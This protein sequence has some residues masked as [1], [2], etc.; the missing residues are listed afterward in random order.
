M[1]CLEV[2]ITDNEKPQT[3]KRRRPRLLPF[4]LGFLFTLAFVGG[5]ING[6]SFGIDDN[7]R[8]Q[9]ISSFY[10][11]L[12]QAASAE[13]AHSGT[14]SDFTPVL[15]ASL[16]NN[17]YIVYDALLDSVS[18]F[19]PQ[20]SFSLPSATTVSM[21]RIIEITKIVLN[22]PELYW[23]ES[24]TWITW[25]DNPDASRTYTIN[26][27]YNMDADERCHTQKSIDTVV[28]S[29]LEDA[30]C[31]TAQEAAEYVNDYLA[32]SV[33]YMSDKAHQTEHPYDMITGPLLYQQAIC[34]GY[35]KTFTY[36][37]AKLGYSSAYCLGYTEDGVF[38]AWNAIRQDGTVLYT[39]STFN[40][41]SS[42]EKKWLNLPRPS[43]G[44]HQETQKYWYEPLI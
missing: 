15:Q 30:D 19:S 13:S 41:S 32:S 18:Q 25:T 20:S 28:S 10:L 39:D 42:F 36:L 6:Y 4:F 3:K 27:D 26:I 43:F 40:A 35:A 12:P 31:Q 24:M 8:N 33:T 38:H 34:S 16:S 21:E 11:H 5:F 37:M 7:Q 22:D 14:C 17:E 2:G 23:L 1:Q 9:L 44:D 29:I